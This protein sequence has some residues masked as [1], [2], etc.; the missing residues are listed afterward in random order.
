MTRPA[1]HLLMA[2][3]FDVYWT[4]VVML[5]ERG[6][7]IWLTLAI[8]AWLR[9]PAA[10]R[11]P[12]LLLAA[13]G[14]GLDAC[15]ALAGLIDFRGDSLLP[16]WI[17]ALWLMFAVVWTRLTRTATLPGR[18]LATAATVGGPVA[19][20]IGARLGAMTLLVPTALGVAAMACGWL[21]LMLLFHLG[22]GRQK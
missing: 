12:A 6:L 4:L 22:M 3:A 1:Q 9:L 18:V 14:C 5:R 19:Y 17:V 11:P 8:F 7:L 20:L 15:W 13:A 16:L 10:S 21:V 2:L